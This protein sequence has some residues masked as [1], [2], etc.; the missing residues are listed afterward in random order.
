MLKI[1]SFIRVLY[2]KQQSNIL[3]S[4]LLKISYVEPH[5]FMCKLLL[6][7]PVAAINCVYSSLQK[8]FYHLGNCRVFKCITLWTATTLDRLIECII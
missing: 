3:K 6:D 4:N 7:F 5:S 8:T 2:P 1:L